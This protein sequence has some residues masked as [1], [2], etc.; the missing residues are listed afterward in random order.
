MSLYHLKDDIKLGAHTQF[1]GRICDTLWTSINFGMYSTQFFMG[2]P[3]GFK[4]ATILENDITECKKILSRYPLS[5]F[6][7][8]PYVANLAGS[9]DILAW[10]DNDDQSRKT[11]FVLKGLQYELD[12]IGRIGSNNCG[13]VIH[14]G[15]YTD[16][17]KGLKTISKSIN[18]LVFKNDA[19]LLLENSAGQG[20]SLAT[21]LEEI[22]MII[23]GVDEEKK[24]N[25]GV[26]IDTCHTFAYGLYNLTKP[27]EVVKLFNDFDDVIGLEYLSL[28]HLNDSETV[29]KSK[30]DRHALIKEG[31]IW[32]KDSSAL[33]VLCSI[34][35]EKQI[36]MVLETHGVDMLKF[37]K[38]L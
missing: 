18:K 36:P 15:N 30:K 3:Q 34:S 22:K 24:R 29:F 38:F 10:S 2:S 33:D 12:T 13:V 7:H 35:I 17:K 16:R 14:P 6:S 37:S 11:E 20:T 27:T 4:R 23:D 32:S 28:I 26:C 1:S 9:K 5:V 31:F 21:T 25:I 8:Y 19:K